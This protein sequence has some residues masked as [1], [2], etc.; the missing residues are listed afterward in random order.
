M[1]FLRF[2]CSYLFS[3]NLLIITNKNLNWMTVIQQW[4]MIKI[5]S[6][7][8]FFFAIKVFNIFHNNNVCEL[9]RNGSIHAF[10]NQY[11]N[12]INNAL[13]SSSI[14]DE[15]ESKQQQK[16]ENAHTSVQDI[17]YSNDSWLIC[18]VQ[19]LNVLSSNKPLGW[20]IQ[21]ANGKQPLC[22]YP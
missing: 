22:Y 8:F 16:G 3:C 15:S 11:R 9:C 13:L 20:R 14:R 7:I 5:F 17:C 6:S 4:K 21:I 1:I 2:S 19:T 12:N 10:N 18:K